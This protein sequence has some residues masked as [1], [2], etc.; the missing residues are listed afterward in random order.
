MNIIRRSED[1]HD[2]FCT[3]YVRSILQP[4]PRGLSGK[5][6]SIFFS[7]TSFPFIYFYFYLF[8]F[9]YFYFVTAR[10]LMEIIR[11]ALP[12]TG[13]ATGGVL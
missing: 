12:L 10:Y 13:A 5:E 6:M 1:V 4:V 2:V 3:S 7:K 11:V 8:F 9:I